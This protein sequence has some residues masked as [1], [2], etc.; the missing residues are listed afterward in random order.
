[1]GSDS[2]IKFSASKAVRSTVSP[3]LFL[4][5][6]PTR[7]RLA[8]FWPERSSTALRLLELRSSGGE[9]VVVVVVAVVVVEEAVEV[10]EAVVEVV[11]EA[12]AGGAGGAAREG[13]RVGGGGIAFMAWFFM[14]ALRMS[15]AFWLSLLLL[16]DKACRDEVFAVL[17]ES[18]SVSKERNAMCPPSG[19]RFLAS[20]LVLAWEL[21]LLAHSTSWN[22][23]MVVLCRA[24]AAVA[25]V[26]V[27]ID[28]QTTTFAKKRKTTHNST[29]DTHHPYEK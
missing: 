20:F 22:T 14:A 7:L 16:G 10:V 11:E 3:R 18:P 24:A 6:V 19:P 25:V 2:S 5:V 12:V 15:G 28:N 26:V 17:G 29:I 13:R 27:A 8:G 4:T 23:S 1:M 9:A 21:A